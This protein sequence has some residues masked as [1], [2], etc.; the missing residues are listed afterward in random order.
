MTVLSAHRAVLNTYETLLKGHDEVAAGT[1]RFRFSKPPGFAFT[2]GQAIT[3]LLIDP[4]PEAN[5]KQRIF[6][7][8]S[9]PFEAELAIATRMRESS[10]FKGALS[11]LPPGAKL[12][13]KG[14]RGAMTLHEDPSRAAVFLAGG[15]GITPFMSMLREAAHEGSTRQL[16]L[17]Y[18]NRSPQ[19]AAFL[20]ELQGLE[21]RVT[22]FRLVTT[23]T[24]VSPSDGAWKGETRKID[25]E[26]IAQA[27]RGLDA[28]VYYLVGPPGFVEAMQQSLAKGGIATEDVRTEE[29]YG[30]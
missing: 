6:S 26:L 5:S 25:Y 14:P 15:I 17:V 11:R 1:M 29:F 20:Q 12:Q 30:Y 7:L 16:C 19:D 27:S 23:M 13:L 3:L 21:E 22:G 24:D 8:V 28:P 4:P 18:S 9:A 2:P 10:A